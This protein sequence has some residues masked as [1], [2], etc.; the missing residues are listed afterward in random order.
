MI[1]SGDTALQEVYMKVVKRG[2]ESDVTPKCPHQ[3][4]TVVMSFQVMMQ[5]IFWT[6]QKC[7][8]VG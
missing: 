6:G 2:S 1:G 7:S 3:C 5:V 8:Y 4:M